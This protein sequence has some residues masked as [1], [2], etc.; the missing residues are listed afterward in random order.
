MHR[1]ILNVR[2]LLLANTSA[3]EDV[4]IQKPVKIWAYMGTILSYHTKL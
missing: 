3:L 1:F 4:K 2:N